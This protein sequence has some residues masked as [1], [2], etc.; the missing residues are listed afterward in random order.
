MP[1]RLTIEDAKKE[2]EKRGGLCLSEEYCGI[3]SK[4]VFLCESNH[5]FRARLD[6]V[7]AGHWCSRCAT[8][9]AQKR[10]LSVA[11]S[12]AQSIA[13]SH[14]GICLEK[15]LPACNEKVSFVCEYGHPFMKRIQEIRA[16]VWCPF[17]GHH[18]TELKD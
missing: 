17:C 15:G 1:R 4:L 7:K 11:L 5:T 3:K 16:G 12:D 18:Q 8:Q 9:A 2:A 13:L 10:L 14:G 6:R